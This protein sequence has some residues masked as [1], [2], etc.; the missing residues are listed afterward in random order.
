MAT[1]ILMERWEDGLIPLDADGMRA[2]KDVPGRT[3]V[4]VS[5]AVP[6][7]IRHHRMFFA[8]LNIVYDAQHDPKQQHLIVYLC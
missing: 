4:R 5:F 1:Q 3:I 7:N 2:L 8:L 6:R